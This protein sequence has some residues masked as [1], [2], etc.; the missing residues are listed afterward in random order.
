MVNNYVQIVIYYN[1]LYNIIDFATLIYAWKDFDNNIRCNIRQST[2]Y[3][4]LN[5]FVKAL[6]KVIEYYKSVTKNIRIFANTNI[7]VDR[8]DKMKTTFQHNIK[9]TKRYLLDQLQYQY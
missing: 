3:T 4:I 9:T 8:F 6:K 2:R 1:R 5:K 7:V